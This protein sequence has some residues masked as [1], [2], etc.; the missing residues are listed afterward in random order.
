MAH[1]I[2]E[3][4]WQLDKIRELVNQLDTELDEADYQANQAEEAIEQTSK[5]EE[6]KENVESLAQQAILILEDDVSSVEEADEQA[7]KVID[8]LRDLVKEL[9]K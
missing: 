8:L 6:A 5:W 1:P 3:T 2:V 4:K 9:E 7:I